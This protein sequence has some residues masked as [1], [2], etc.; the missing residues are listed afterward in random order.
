MHRQSNFKLARDL[1]NP[2]KLTCLLSLFASSQLFS[3]E[4]GYVSIFDGE[5]LNGWTSART[6]GNGDYGP[7]SVNKEEKA[8]H[9]YAGK[10]ANSKQ[11]TD[12]LYTD[13]EYSSF[14][15]KLEYKWL[16]KRF[17]PRTNWDRDAGL[18]P[19]DKP[20]G[21]KSAGRFHTGD[22]FVLGKNLRT[23][24]SSKDK[25]YD[26]TL[27]PKTGGSVHTKKGKE[28]PLGEWN[29]MEL[30]V[31]GNEKAVFI[32]NGETVL[33]TTNFTQKNK[34]GETVPLEK[35]RIGLQA[36]WAEILIKNVIIKEL[37]NKP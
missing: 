25:F 2:L 14:I 19:G 32:F 15:L 33:E 30:Q 11:I 26:P 36:E 13:K 4:E 1:K 23:D 35:G 31:Y 34:D 6:K 12:V 3:E 16:D 20:N 9:V 7:F 21:K 27:E 28:N 37:P 29:Q 18:S 22:L 5:T 8:I 24:T 10:K 17:A